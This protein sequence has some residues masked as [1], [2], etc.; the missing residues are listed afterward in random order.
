MLVKLN[1]KYT[2]LLCLFPLTHHLGQMSLNC[3]SSKI[4]TFE[5]TISNNPQMNAIT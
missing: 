2:L 4:S 5:S 3:L 1:L